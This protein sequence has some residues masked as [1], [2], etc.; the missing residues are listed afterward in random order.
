MS[1]LLWLGMFSACSTDD[2]KIDSSLPKVQ[3]K[4][5]E[6]KDLTGVMHYDQNYQVW[7]ISVGNN[8]GHDASIQRLDILHN[9]DS[10]FKQEGLPVLFSGETLQWIDG[11]EGDPLNSGNL[12]IIISNIINVD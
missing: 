4:I 9:I 12:V 3:N 8:G 10:A 2:D 7:Y 5:G 11:A 1:I 6:V